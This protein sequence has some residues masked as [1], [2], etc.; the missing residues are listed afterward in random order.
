MG[1]IALLICYDDTY[2]DYLLLASVRGANIIAHLSSP[3]QLMSNE[4]GSNLNHSTIANINTLSGWLGTYIIASSRTNIEINPK[5]QQE[6]YFV[7]SASI[8]D[9]NGHKLAQAKVSSYQNLQP[10]ETIYANIDTALYNNEAK[11]SLENRR[12]PSL[13]YDL[14]LTKNSNNPEASQHPKHINAL[15]LQYTPSLLSK[16]ENLKKI[17]ALIDNNQTIKPNLIVLP[18]HSLIG[19]LDKQA[20]I[21]QA[22][23]IEGESIN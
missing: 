5:S 20:L 12:K 6:I 16:K 21:S 4:K 7:G 23:T 22:E 8:W 17:I 10:A 14:N 11:N 13:Y 15:V 2:L 9:P 18:Q 1:E 19:S 3:G